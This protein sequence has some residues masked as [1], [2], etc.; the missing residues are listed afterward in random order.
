MLSDLSALEKGD[1]YFSTG[2]ELS[3]I[4]FD[5]KTCTVTVKPAGQAKY[6]V[7]FIGNGGTVLARVG[8]HGAVYNLRGNE[9][10]VRARITDS[11]GFRAWTQPVFTGK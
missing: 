1:F 2:V 6:T 11:N 3:D 10:Y 7:E 4:G 9:G 5:G 8:S